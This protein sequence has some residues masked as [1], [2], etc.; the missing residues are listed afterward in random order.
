[1]EEMLDSSRTSRL[2]NVDSLLITIYY[3]T[4]KKHKSSTNYKHAKQF[5]VH[6][7]GRKES[8]FSKAVFI[9]KKKSLI[10]KRDKQLRLT[11]KGMEKVKELLRDVDDSSGHMI[12]KAGE[13]FFAI[14][15]LEE[16]LQKNVEADEV[17]LCDPYISQSTLFPLLVLKGK[18]SRIRIITCNIQ[19][20]EIFKEYA[21]KLQHEAKLK[22]EVRRICG[23]IHDRYIIAGKMC[24]LI[25][26]SI[27]DLG[28]KDTFIKDVSEVCRLIRELF[29]ERWKEADTFL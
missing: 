23:K 8:S 5:Y 6:R 14:R 27:K 16:L 2:T 19:D 17:L 21:M 20:D 25:G 13:P 24:W 4:Y 1:M 9:A 10:D 12:I 11:A 7:L 3:L 26:T 18:V 22:V 15:I 29:E 28:K